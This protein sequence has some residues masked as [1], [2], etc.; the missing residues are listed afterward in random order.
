MLKLF[1][2]SPNV[3][4]LIMFSKIA[5]L[6][7]FLVIC[8]VS[9]LISPTLC[10]YWPQSSSLSQSLPTPVFVRE[11]ASLVQFI[12]SAGVVIPCAVS[13]G[14]DHPSPPNIYWI[15]RNGS[16][17]GSDAGRRLQYI[18]S[19]SSLVFLPFDV[20]TDYN[21]DIHDQIYR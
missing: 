17:V 2:Q 21:V 13:V 4:Q 9:V 14:S 8:F 3:C 1:L 19:D 16:R 18:R 5:F 7:T 10:I 6:V 15:T 12:A 20:D 11:P